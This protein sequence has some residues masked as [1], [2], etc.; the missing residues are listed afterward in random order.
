MEL[1]ATSVP[2]QA[3]SFIQFVIVNVLVT[4]AL[5]LTRVIRV[6]KAYARSK[7]GPNL[8]EEERARVFIG[9]EPLT[10]PEE[11]DFPMAFAEVV[12]YF[13]IL[14]VYSCIAPIM[15]YVMF[16]MFGLLL[17]T[18][19]NQFIFIYS[20]H[21]DQGGIL[22]TR[23][24]KITLVAMLI[25]QVTLIGIMSIKQSALSSALLVP[26]GWG[27]FLFGLYLEQQHYKVTNSL[28]S[29]LCKRADRKNRG[30]LDKTFLEGQYIQPSLK[31]KILLPTH[32]ND[33]ENKNDIVVDD[34]SNGDVQDIKF[35]QNPYETHE[36]DD[37]EFNNQVD[38]NYIAV[39][40]NSSVEKVMFT[41]NPYK[42]HESDDDDKADGSDD[43]VDGSDVSDDDDLWC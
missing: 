19:K 38:N 32:F 33:E 3:K 9:L 12:L 13:M 6:V 29:T 14:L 35:A 39:V 15:S 31:V 27:T 17:I 42:S 8:S 43:K 37:N 18:Y 26:L 4:C 16:V 7:V 21:S 23:M 28:P 1:L 22:W 5:E 41:Q 10:K 2:G 34:I 20:A 36:T 40:D 24:I 30:R 11:M 25:A